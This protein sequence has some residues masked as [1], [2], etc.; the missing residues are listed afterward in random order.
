MEI[1]CGK[2]MR[3]NSGGVAGFDGML[4]HV[5]AFLE[6]VRFISSNVVRTGVV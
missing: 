1:A 6:F 3:R 4:M 5:L 2:H